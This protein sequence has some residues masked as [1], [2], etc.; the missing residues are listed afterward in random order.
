MRQGPI[1]LRVMCRN[2]K[3]QP[4]LMEKENHGLRN[5]IHSCGVPGNLKRRGQPFRKWKPASL[6]RR[7]PRKRTWSLELAELWQFIPAEDPSLDATT[8]PFSV[9]C[10]VLTIM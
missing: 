2:A 3:Y 6:H 5:R 7:Q 4:A 10:I 1:R 8:K 9:Y